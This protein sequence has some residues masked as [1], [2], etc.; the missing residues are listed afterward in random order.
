M[1]RTYFSI[2]A[3]GGGIAIGL[4]LIVP[5]LR[6]NCVFFKSRCAAVTFQLGP[7]NSLLVRDKTT[8][9]TYWYDGQKYIIA[10]GNNLPGRCPS[11]VTV[12][13]TGETIQISPPIAAGAGC[14]RISP[15]PCEDAEG[16]PFDG[17]KLADGSW[18]CGTNDAPLVPVS[19]AGA[20]VASGK[21]VFTPAF[22]VDSKTMEL[23]DGNYLCAKPIQDVARSFST[24]P[25]RNLTYAIPDGD[26]TLDIYQT[27]DLLK[28]R[29]IFKS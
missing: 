24:H 5:I 22:A 1:T 16:N 2:C 14:T 6:Q 11:L 19:V 3:L 23:V 18:C 17:T 10:Y 20:T 12:N 26:F 8:G 15:D 7:D 4:F 29:G 28:R 13:G 9:F 21:H 25:V 27:F